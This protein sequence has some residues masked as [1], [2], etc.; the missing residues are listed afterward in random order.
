MA[1]NQTL[2]AKQEHSLELTTPIHVIYYVVA[3]VLK[4]FRYSKFLVPK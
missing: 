1:T 4:I 3:A 2:D